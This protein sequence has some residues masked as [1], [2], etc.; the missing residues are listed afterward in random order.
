MING[1]PDAYHSVEQIGLMAFRTVEKLEQVGLMAFRTVEK[2]KS[3]IQM[4]A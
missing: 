2:L 4:A 1:A 3:L